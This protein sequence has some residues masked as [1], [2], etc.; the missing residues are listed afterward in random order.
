MVKA[1]EN[2]MQAAE[3]TGRPI[4]DDDDDDD[5][6]DEDRRQW[7]NHENEMK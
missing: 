6:G 2:E 5:D 3:G 4:D 7:M 1:R